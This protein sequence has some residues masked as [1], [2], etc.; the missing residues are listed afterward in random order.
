V[1]TEA[2]VLCSTCDARE[3]NTPRV[4]KNMCGLILL[5]CRR[6]RDYSENTGDTGS[7]WLSGGTQD[8]INCGSALCATMHNMRI[9]IIVSATKRDTILATIYHD[10]DWL[11]VSLLT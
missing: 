1:Q 5:L 8:I 2:I 6:D 7:V 10:F 9:S 3:R 4:D 11:N